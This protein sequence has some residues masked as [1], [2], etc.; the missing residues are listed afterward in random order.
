MA[1]VLIAVFLAA[2]VALFIYFHGRRPVV[3]VKPAPKEATHKERLE[4][5]NHG[6][7]TYSYRIRI[8]NRYIS[9]ENGLSRVTLP[10]GAATGVI[11]DE[12]TAYVLNDPITLECAGWLP[13]NN[14]QVIFKMLLAD[15]R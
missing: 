12:V 3:E 9:F 15:M 7:Q 8:G 11:L 13:W 5:R 6:Q 10:P 1:E 14:K 2:S 4:L